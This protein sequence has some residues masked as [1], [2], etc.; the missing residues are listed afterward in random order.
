[1]KMKS[2]PTIYFGTMPLILSID[3]SSDSDYPLL[4][5]S[6]DNQSNDTEDSDCM[7]RMS[8]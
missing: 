4:E 8:L 6:S 7:F 3:M 1:M 5:M 2:S